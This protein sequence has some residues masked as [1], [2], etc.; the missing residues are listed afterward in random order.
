MVLM[1]LR[2]APFRRMF[3]EQ[4]VVF[5]DLLQQKLLLVIPRHAD[6]L[7]AAVGDDDAVPLAAGDLGGQ[8]LAAVARQVF[9]GGDE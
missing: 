4:F 2:L 1:R 3:A 7:E 9:L 6:P 8:L 5:G